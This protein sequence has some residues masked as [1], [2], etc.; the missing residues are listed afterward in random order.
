MTR[1]QVIRFLNKEWIQH[2]EFPIIQLFNSHANGIRYVS[3]FFWVICE[4]LFYKISQNVTNVD[5]RSLAL[6]LSS[7]FDH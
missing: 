1:S 4:K 2:V 3:P 5:F 6:I 7:L